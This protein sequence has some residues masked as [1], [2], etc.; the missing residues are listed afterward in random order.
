M[1]PVTALGLAS[2][3]LTFI[4]FAGKIVA[5][6]YEIY[7]SAAGATDGNAHVD[8]IVGDLAE[9]TAGLVTTI[10]GRTKNEI[11]LKDLASKCE[12]VASKLQ[13]LLR[14]LR[15]LGDHTTWKSLK[16]KIKSMRREPEIV[17][18]E[19]QLGDYR[20][21]ILTRLTVM[22]SQ[23]Q[24]S[25]KL[26]LDR[27][28]GMAL[29]LSSETATQLS[30]LRQGILKDAK[31]LADDSAKASL[32]A[33]D[34]VRDE[35]WELRQSLETLFSKMKTLPRENT[36]LQNLFFPSM[37]LREEA[38]SDP[39]EGTFNWI[40]KK[41]TEAEESLAGIDEAKEEPESDEAG[42]SPLPVCYPTDPAPQE[43]LER[44]RENRAIFLSWLQA[45]GGLF[46]ISGKAGSGK[47]TLMKFLC[48]HRRIKEELGKWAAD[49]NKT[50]VFASFYFWNSGDSMQMSLDG[51]CRSMLFETLQHCP[52]LIPTV[53]PMQWRGLENDMFYVPG[54]LFSNADITKAFEMLTAHGTFP[55]HR[56]CFFID[57]LDE[58]EGSSR[59]HV[60]LAKRLQSWASKEDV[61]ICASSRPYLEFDNLGVENQKLH[62]HELTWFD[63]YLF[64]RQTIERDENFDQIR[65]SYLDLVYKIVWRSE[66]VFLWARLVVSSLL[67]GMLRHDTVKALEEKLEVVPQ[68]INKLYDRMLDSLDPHDRKRAAKM[69]LMTA[70]YPFDRVPLNCLT[71][72]WVDELDNPNFPP[73]DG[74]KPTSWRP[75]SIMADDAQRQLKSLTKGL[76]ETAPARRP[77]PEEQWDSETPGPLRVVQFFHRTVRDFVMER[78]SLEDTNGQHQSFFKEE[79]YY[80]LMLAD[81]TLGAPNYRRAYWNSYMVPEVGASLFRHKLPL[82]LLEGFSRVL[83]DGRGDS[84]VVDVHNYA[85]YFRGKRMNYGVGSSEERIS[86]VHMA[87]YTGQGEYVLREVSKKP[88]LLR[89]DGNLHVLLSAVLGGHMDLAL[90]L[91]ARGSSLAD[92]IKSFFPGDDAEAAGIP[93]VPVWFALGGRFIQYQPSAK[94]FDILELILRVHKVDASDCGFILVE[95]RDIDSQAGPR[96]EEYATLEEII[97][98]LEPENMD[99]L[100]S[101]LNKHKQSSY[102]D[103]MKR[104]ASRFISMFKQTED[105]LPSRTRILTLSKPPRSTNDTDIAQTLPLQ[106][107]ALE[108]LRGV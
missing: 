102:V 106:Y 55:K 24:S 90:A 37:K 16:V 36:I 74:K 26:R 85:G 7:Q 35:I 41:E 8:T 2:S 71:Y 10:P 6:T 73:L 59:D 25:I 64:C 79:S 68:D 91:I 60:L 11:A 43:N 9:I 23:D 32:L 27:L 14:S 56:F 70:H 93:T 40:L 53:F 15:V 34:Q 100:L 88:E 57:G 97:C 5:G 54:H 47:S 12:A 4:D 95:A 51:L 61:K 50:L 94:N 39:E 21:Q 66:G 72:G 52:D 83:D 28:Q 92:V 75:A 31:Q 1:D 89:A 44:R 77:F 81:L 30:L 13:T 86:F 42:N 84:Y 108:A 49:K 45:G 99:R 98:D 103:G 101:L 107:G 3:I 87:A 17:R 104:F 105:L 78:L 33:T 67:A 29:N 96:L 76:L 63:I 80:R 82:T 65:E 38:I 62:L 20:A 19:K 46:H 18:L 48:R 58:Y 22:L 69:L